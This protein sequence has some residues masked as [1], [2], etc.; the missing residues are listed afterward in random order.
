MRTMNATVRVGIFTI[1]KVAM[2]VATLDM[3][4][5]TVM[6]TPIGMLIKIVAMIVMMVK[7]E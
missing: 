6:I 7:R 1:T 5:A 4:I 2:Q 3:A